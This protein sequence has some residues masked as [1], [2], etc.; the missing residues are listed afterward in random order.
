MRDGMDEP[1]ES[2]HILWE[3]PMKDCFIAQ[4]QD[5]FSWETNIHNLEKKK[6]EHNRRVYDSYYVSLKPLKGNSGL[7][8]EGWDWS[9]GRDSTKKF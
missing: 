6:R 8:S 7:N 1:N 9:N 5:A 3:N 4:K 2:F